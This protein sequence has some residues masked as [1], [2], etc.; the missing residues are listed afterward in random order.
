MTMT[1]E[2]FGVEDVEFADPDD[3]TRQ[4]RELLEMLQEATPE[5]FDRRLRKHVSAPTESTQFVFRHPSIVEATRDSLL[6][7]RTAVKGRA[8]HAR[9]KEMRQV[10]L[11][12]Y[13][14]YSQE[15]KLIGAFVNRA[16]A[17]AAKD[18]PRARAERLLGRLRFKELTAI[19]RDY[20]AGL[21]DPEVEARAKER[22]RQADRPG[23]PQSPK[24]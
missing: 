8:Q 18:T 12:Q 11:D 6:R 13:D 3:L 22:M 5:E 19:R 9:N 4:E 20:E 24:T 21:S 7:L 2:R 15:L 10:Y 16:M 14:K 1:D 23:R 17:E